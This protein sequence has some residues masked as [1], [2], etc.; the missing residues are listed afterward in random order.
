MKEVHRLRGPSKTGR[1]VKNA[2][3]VPS[4][5]LLFRGLAHRIVSFATFSPLKRTVYAT[6][7]LTQGNMQDELHLRRTVDC[8]Q[9]LPLAGA[10][11]LSSLAT[12]LV[13]KY[14]SDRFI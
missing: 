5:S 13:C 9:I 6:V 3:T 7:G 8:R 2:K 4:C 11:D 14:G 10:V 12:A 1:D